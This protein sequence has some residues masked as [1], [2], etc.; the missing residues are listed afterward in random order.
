MKIPVSKKLTL[1]ILEKMFSMHW[2]SF[3]QLGSLTKKVK[4][5][6]FELGFI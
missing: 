1:K 2:P 4:F 5:S 6:L 3:D